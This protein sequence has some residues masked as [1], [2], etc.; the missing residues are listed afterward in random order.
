MIC[1]VPK[2]T[3]VQKEELKKRLNMTRKKRQTVSDAISLEIII[4]LDGVHKSF[5][6]SYY[7]DPSFSDFEED[8]KVKLFGSDQKVL[9]IQV[10]LHCSSDLQYYI[11]H[12]GRP[13]SKW[14]EHGMCKDE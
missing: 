9:T 11:T 13:H 7:R 2:L 14:R 3:P 12:Q 6:I 5:I 4:H 8:D 10:R 1:P